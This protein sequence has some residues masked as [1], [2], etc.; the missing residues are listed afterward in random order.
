MRPTFN[1]WIGK[2]P[3]RKKWQLTSAFLPEEFHGQRTLVGYSAW[4]HKVL[5]TFSH[6][7]L[8]L[9]TGKNIALTVWAFINKAI[10]LL[11]N[12]L[13]RCVIAFL[14]S[15]LKFHDCSHHL[16]WFGSPRKLILPLFSLFLHIFVIKWWSHGPWLP[17]YRQ[18][19]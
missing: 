8:Y 3:W 10:S 16:Q 17:V 5:T 4:G 12:M 13:S 18:S 14:P 15:I 11:F 7:H 2:I 1:S 9:T 6:S 19:G